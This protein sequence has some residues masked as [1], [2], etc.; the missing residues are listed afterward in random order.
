MEALTMGAYTRAQVDRASL[1]TDGPIRFT[2]ATEGVKADGIDL[3]MSGAQL[4]RY[5]RNPV[6]GYGH[7]YWGRDDLPI[8]RASNVEVSG[9]QLLIDVTFDQADDFARKVESKYRGGYLSAVSIGFDVTA[10]DGKGSYWGGGIAKE[11]ELNEVSAVPIPMDAEAVVAGGRAMRAALLG[12]LDVMLAG[13]EAPVKVEKDQR[14]FARTV[15]VT[16]ELIADTDPV[17]L[18]LHIARAL[19]RDLETDVPPEP[20]DVD[21]DAARHLLAAFALERG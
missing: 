3:R 21:D 17:L 13:R 4:D 12:D 2:A 15:R 1:D 9:R 7:R 6:F 20:A 16:E 18:G 11:W 5:R 10:W 19:R 8:G 14:L